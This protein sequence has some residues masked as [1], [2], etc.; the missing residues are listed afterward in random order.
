MKTQKQIEIEKLLNSELKEVTGGLTSSDCNC[1]SGAGQ[2]LTV[3]STDTNTDQKQPEP[4]LE[5]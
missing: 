2:Y 4:E 5:A 3:P 1:Q